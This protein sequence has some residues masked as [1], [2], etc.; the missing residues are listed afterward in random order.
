MDIREFL[1]FNSL[2][3]IT[4]PPNKL[5]TIPNAVDLAMDLLLSTQARKHTGEST[6]HQFETT[7]LRQHHSHQ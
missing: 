2:Y 7:N 1:I 6:Y 5:K 4:K 3:T